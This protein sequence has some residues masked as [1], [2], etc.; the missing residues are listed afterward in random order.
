M[1]LHRFA[2]KLNNAISLT[3]TAISGLNKAVLLSLASACALLCA[4]T[5]PAYVKVSPIEHINEP[6]NW[7]DRHR[8]SFDRKQFFFTKKN[9][10]NS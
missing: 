3:I 9:Q 10:K 2:A 5:V 1:R 7:Q 8:S 6:S 4:A